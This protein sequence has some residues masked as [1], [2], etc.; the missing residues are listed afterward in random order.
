MARV[1]AVL[2][3]GAATATERGSAGCDDLYTAG[4]TEGNSITVRQGNTLQPRH[5]IYE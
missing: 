5:Q 4:D 1:Q 3:L 2:L